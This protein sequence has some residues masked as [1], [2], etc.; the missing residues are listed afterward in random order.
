MG[1]CPSGGAKQ[2]FVSMSM[3]QWPSMTVL[4]TSSGS[5]AIWSGDWNRGHPS[6]PMEQPVSG[7]SFIRGWKLFTSLP[8]GSNLT[9]LGEEA[10]LTAIKCSN[11]W[12]AYFSEADGEHWVWPASTLRP[13]WRK[14]LRSGSLQSQR[15]SSPP[16]LVVFPPIFFLNASLEACVGPWKGRLQSLSEFGHALCLSPARALRAMAS[17]TRGSY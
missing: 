14:C 8:W 13:A 4:C 12:R 6:G 10:L 15:P 16:F 11:R 9:P 1:W 5:Y 17:K 2:G 7:A 3:R